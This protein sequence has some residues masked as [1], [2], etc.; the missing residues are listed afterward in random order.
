[1]TASRRNH[2]DDGGISYGRQEIL[3]ADKFFN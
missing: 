3:I 1:L 2:Q